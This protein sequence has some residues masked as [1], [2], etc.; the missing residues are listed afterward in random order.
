MRT[1]EKVIFRECCRQLAIRRRTEG[2]PH[3]EIVDEL[4]ALNDQCVL[5][6]I[7]HHPTP[8]WSLGLYDH[9]TMTVQF[10]IDE[11]LDVF[12]LED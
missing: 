2:L 3:E 9:I 12:D 6:L 4:E 5:S 10:G 7:G 1:G 8:E 11:V